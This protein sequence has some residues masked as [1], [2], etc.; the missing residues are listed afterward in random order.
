MATFGSKNSGGDIFF[1]LLRR[2]KIQVIIFHDIWPFGLPGDAKCPDPK[3]LTP[4]M[5]CIWPVE[6]AENKKKLKRVAVKFP[7]LMI[8]NFGS[9][10]H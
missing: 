1:R 2:S 5:D 6:H 9:F 3:V 7:F 8:S 4:Y 10:D